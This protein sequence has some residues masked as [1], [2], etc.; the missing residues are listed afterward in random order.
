[1]K[2]KKLLIL[3]LVFV[4]ILGLAYAAYTFLGDRVD[5][6]QITPQSTDEAPQDLPEAP[7]FTVYDEVGNPVK[8]SDFIGKKPIV[9]NFWASWCGPCRSEMPDFNEVSQEL[10]DSVQFLMINVT[11]GNRETVEIASQFVKDNGF[12]F[13]VYYDTSSTAA[14]TYQAYGLPTTYFINMEGKIAARASAAIP[15][16]LLMQ[17]ISLITE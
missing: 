16:S 3:V 17:G 9:L 15:R 5:A 13:P 14:L 2:N 6:N 1:M 7:D 4:L 10:K 8:L 11:D 12:T